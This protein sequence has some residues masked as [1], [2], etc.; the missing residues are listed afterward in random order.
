LSA[1]I[2]AAPPEAAIT[3]TPRAFG[4]PARGLQQRL[5]VVDLDETGALDGRGI[6][7]GGARQ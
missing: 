6:G 3:A 1:P 2:T 5:D 4:A 7:G